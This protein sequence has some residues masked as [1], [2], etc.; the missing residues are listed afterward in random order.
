MPEHATFCS[1]KTEPA[2]HYRVAV[3]HKAPVFL[4]K[5]QSGTLFGIGWWLESYSWVKNCGND[6]RYP[7]FT[8]EMCL[9][10]NAP[11]L[12]VSSPQGEVVEE[13]QV[14][15]PMSILTS[16][17][18]LLLLIRSVPKPSDTVR[19]LPCSQ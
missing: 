6:E 2:R 4:S 13:F 16:L 15:P 7:K 11:T 18:V 19:E 10:R 17:R 12:V 9:R 8:I 1:V 3:T 5:A 14:Y